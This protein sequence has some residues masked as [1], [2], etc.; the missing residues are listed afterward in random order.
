MRLGDI[1]IVPL[2]DGD[3]FARPEFFGLDADFTSHQQL[4]DATGALRLPIGVFALRGA[5]GVTL[6][7]AGIGPVNNAMFAG[8]QLLADMKRHGIVEAEIREVICTHLHPD[9]V[10]WV[11]RKQDLSPVFPNAR[12]IVHAADWNFF[13]DQRGQDMEQHVVDGLL[14]LAESNRVTLFTGDATVRSGVNLLATPGHTPGHSIV[15]VSSGQQRV[16][17]LGDAITC[18][19][20]LQEA[21]WGA[22]SDVDPLLAKR[23]REA[24]WR[25]L[26]NPASMGAGAHFPG[27]QFGRVL[28]AHGRRWSV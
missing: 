23:T 6:V 12:V 22:I 24:L 14:R 26:E 11:V 1:E 9:H 16:L 25:E 20:Q 19:L 13:V 18:P 3:F 17:L 5:D 8:G 7:D 15:V 27:L 4:L 28:R 21:D 10:G 2:S